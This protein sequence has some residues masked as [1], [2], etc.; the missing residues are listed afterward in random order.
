MILHGNSLMS[1][2]NATTVQHL[3]T[4]V[5]LFAHSIL[6]TCSILSKESACLSRME[7]ATAL[8]QSHLHISSVAIFGPALKPRFSSSFLYES[9]V[10]DLKQEGGSRLSAAAV[11]PHLLYALATIV[12]VLP[13]VST[14]TNKN[15]LDQN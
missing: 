8:S 6:G 13:S 3:L 12:W 7:H 2:E 1:L 15:V 9:S 4:I 5:F 14:R 10:Y 11:P